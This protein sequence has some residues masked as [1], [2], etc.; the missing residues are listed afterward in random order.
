MPASFRSSSPARAHRAA[1]AAILLALLAGCGY[2]GPLY[3][4]PPPAAA[5]P[6]LT[7]PPQQAAQQPAAEPAPQ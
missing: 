3:L 5:D 7:E 6:A 2:K 1:T 4:P